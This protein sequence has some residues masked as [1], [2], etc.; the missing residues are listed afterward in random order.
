MSLRYVSLLAPSGV[1]LLIP[2]KN[3]E[4]AIR[5]P[6]QTLLDM[7]MKMGSVL[8]AANTSLISRPDPPGATFG[9]GCSDTVKSY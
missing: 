1:I 2:A 6:T 5:I 9:I 8:P 3:A 4:T 7:I